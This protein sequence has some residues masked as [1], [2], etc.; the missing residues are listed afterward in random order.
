M[1]VIPFMQFPLLKMGRAFIPSEL[2]K[3]LI[4]NVNYTD[5]KHK[6]NVMEYMRQHPNRPYVHSLWSSVPEDPNEYSRWCKYFALYRPMVE[7][8]SIAFIE[9]S[10]CDYILSK[11]PERVIASMFVNEE[12]YLVVSNL[13]DAPYSLELQGTWR[14][15]ESGKIGSS[16]AVGKEKLLFLVKE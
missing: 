7:E 4:V 9:L 13:T 5:Y 2:P 10:E 1:K 8:N 16:F 14:D 12:T 11:L 6:A 15:R 3:E